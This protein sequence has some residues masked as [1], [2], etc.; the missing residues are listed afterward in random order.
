MYPLLQII[1]YHILHKIKT[2][3]NSNFLIILKKGKIHNLTELFNFKSNN[4]N[5]KIR[6]VNKKKMRNI[7][8]YIKRLKIKLIKMKNLK[9]IKLMTTHNKLVK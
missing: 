9:V 3:K 5:Y 1:K 4:N 6:I 8:I 2:M 7:K